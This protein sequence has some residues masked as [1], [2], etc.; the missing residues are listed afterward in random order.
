M[1][2]RIIY[3]VAVIFLLI[4]SYCELKAQSTTEKKKI[5][6]S[7]IDILPPSPIL[8][9]P[10]PDQIQWQ[11]METYAF[12]HFSLNTFNNMEWGY[13][14]TPASTFNPSDL[15]CDQWVSTLKAAGMKGVILTAK[16]HDGFCLWPTKTTEYSVKNSPWRNGKGDVVKELSDACKRHGLKFGIYLSPWDRNSA[17]YG[18][19]EYIKIYH[20]QINELISNYGPLFE[21][22]FD[23]ANGGDGWY[24]GAKEIR[25]IPKDYYQYEKT[26]EM[27]KAKHPTAIIFGGNFADIRWIGNESGIAGETNWAP[28]SEINWT[29]MGRGMKNGTKWL[30]GECD[31]S[32]RPGWFYHPWEDTQVRSLGNLIDLYYKSVG[33]NATFLLNFPIALN[34]KIHPIDSTRIIEWHQAMKNELKVNLLKGAKVSASNT[35]GNLYSAAKVTDGNWDTYWATSDGVNQGSLTLNLRKPALVNR[36]MIQEYITLGQR[37]ASFNVETE[38][39]GKWSPIVTKDST[40]TVGYKRIIRFST[41]KASRIRINFTDAKGPLCINNVEAF[42]APMLME[43]P[44][45]TRNGKDLVEIENPNGGTEIYYSLDGSEPNSETSNLYI[46]PFVFMQKGIVK[47]VAFDRQQNKKSLVGTRRF[48]IP[49][50]YYKVIGIDDRKTSE[51][52]DGKSYYAYYFPEGTRELVI[53]LKKEETIRGFVY[54][55]DQGPGIQGHIVRY[56]FY[57][58]DKLV[59]SGE[60]PNIKHNRIEQVITFPPVKGQ[61]VRLKAISILED[62]KQMSIGEFSLLT[63][64]E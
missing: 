37:I 50:S 4:G 25:T 31:V 16:H 43:E 52:F 23:G 24:G 36:L 33:R 22:W 13:G 64:D 21:Y 57:V 14:D 17:H 46:K 9:V 32:I 41:V 60:F 51:I 10:T 6:L 35:R 61:K 63:K 48:D 7:A 39:N 29:T 47:A 30:P 53:E 44:T 15:D 1:T 49:S 20:E 11:K 42:L 45:I 8:P 38:T 54:T 18:K 59:A 55:P 40:T 5:T 58:E 34:G 3:S 27:I 28:I 12:I 62:A 26:F 2:K 56:E 19:E